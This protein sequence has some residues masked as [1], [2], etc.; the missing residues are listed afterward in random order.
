MGSHLQ[1][2][3]HIINQEALAKRA[4]DLEVIRGDLLQKNLLA[5]W[6]DVAPA[7]WIAAA[8]SIAAIKEVLIDVVCYLMHT[9]E[10]DFLKENFGQAGFAKSNEQSFLEYAIPLLMETDHVAEEEEL[11]LDWS[12]VTFREHNWFSWYSSK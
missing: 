7:S 11:N 10:P 2:L 12:E 9:Y 4:F 1:A 3:Q 6:N 8:N 5:D